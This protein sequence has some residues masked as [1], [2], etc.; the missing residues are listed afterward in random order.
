MKTSIRFSSSCA[1]AA[2][3]SGCFGTEVPPDKPTEHPLSGTTAPGKVEDATKREDKANERMPSTFDKQQ[4]QVS[5]NRGA[6][7]AAECAKIHAEGPFGEASVVL[8]IDNKGKIEDAQLSPPFAGTPI[9]KC[10]E[11]SFEHESVP[12]WDGPD[13]K[14]TASVTLKKADTPPPPADPKKKKK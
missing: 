14:I 4:T 7:Q 2:L 10:V 11:Q 5:V 12:P 6:R 9:G 8:I 3:L 1:L 13:E